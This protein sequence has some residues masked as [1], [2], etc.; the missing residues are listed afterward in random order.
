M[1]GTTHLANTGPK[2][3]GVESKVGQG[4]GEQCTAEKQHIQGPLRGE[5]PKSRKLRRGN[6][7]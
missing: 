1:M 6:F 2:W 7:N 5:Y 4:R 3:G